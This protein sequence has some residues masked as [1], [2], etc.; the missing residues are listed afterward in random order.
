MQTKLIIIRGNSGSG[1]TTLAQHVQAAV[2]GALLVSQDVVRRQMLMVRDR[3][4]NLAIS[5]IEQIALYGNGRVP[6]VIVEGIL[7]R[8][9]YAAMLMH[10]QTQFTHTDAYYF[11]IPFATTLARHQTRPQAA[12]FG[13]NE[14]R[15]WWVA[16]DELGGENEH[17]FDEQQTLAIELSTVLTNLNE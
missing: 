1:K 12:T 11:D 6:L 14:M 9:R 13:A 16:D 10:L 7:V 17:I 8:A 3:P 5:L 4:H 15:D 2:P